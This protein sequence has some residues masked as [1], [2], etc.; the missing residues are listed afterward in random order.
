MRKEDMDIYKPVADMNSEEM[1]GLVE[2]WNIELDDFLGY[3]LREEKKKAYERMMEL[4]GQLQALNSSFELLLCGIDNRSRHIS[5]HIRFRG[6]FL[7]MD[8][9]MLSIFSEMYSISDFAVESTQGTGF[10]LTLCIR[11]IWK[12]FVEF[13]AND[14]WM[15]DFDE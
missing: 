15:D 1:K 14:S 3:E 8:K 12:T 9:R 11:N 13:P 10:L 4:F 6:A 7:P 5:F 2:D